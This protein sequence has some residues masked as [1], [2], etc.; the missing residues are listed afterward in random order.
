MKN[1]ELGCC[2]IG[3]GSHTKLIVYTSTLSIHV[4]GSLIMMP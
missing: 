4:S 3:C 1:G 2:M